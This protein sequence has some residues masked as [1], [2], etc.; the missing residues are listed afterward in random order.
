MIE[1]FKRL[2]VQNWRFS[3][4]LHYCFVFL[5]NSAV[6]IGCSWLFHTCFHTKIFRKHNFQMHYNVGSSTILVE[7]LKI[8][9]NC[10]TFA[11]S[12]SNLLGKMWIRVFYAL[13]SFF[14]RSCLA[15]MAKNN[16]T[17]KQIDV[18]I[19][20]TMKHGPA[21]KHTEECKVYRYTLLRFKL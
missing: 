17:E 3:Y 15:V 5:H 16:P 1:L 10:R 21:W 8:R 14:F 18:E 12:P 19:Q 7:S 9:N 2:W 13:L 11:T 20:A 6:R 4:F